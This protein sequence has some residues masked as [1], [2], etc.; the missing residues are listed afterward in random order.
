MSKKISVL[1]WIAAFVC[2]IAIVFYQR[3]TGPTHPL[4]ASEM[5]EGSEV[6]YKFLRSFTSLQNFPVKV[7]TGDSVNSAF[8]KYRRYKSS[9]EWSE[10]EMKKEAG[11]FSGFL[12]GEPTA[13]KL[14]YSVKLVSGEKELILNKGNTVV[15]RF[16]DEV[17]SIFLL[18]HIIFM[19]LSFF[20]AIRTGFE[21]LRKNGN[22]LWMV[23]W[24][25]GIVIIGGLILGPI[26]Q[27]YA[28]GDLWTGFPFG[29]DLTDNKTLFAF[30]FWLAAFLLK[31]KSRWWVVTASIMMIVV[32]LIPHSAL[33]S[34]L[35]YE[36]GKMKNKFSHRIV[37]EY[38]IT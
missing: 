2:T 16:K 24:T 20:F 36:T 22:Y 8:L 28:F 33:G 3:M 15:V 5:F 37:Q 30:I 17:P 26:V 14:E 21:A 27:K 23:N 34:E 9:D 1:L 12:P 25:L 38:K 7:K 4:K 29:Y 19:I 31:K 11:E 13:G 32:Y 10:F 18:T 35:D 6:S